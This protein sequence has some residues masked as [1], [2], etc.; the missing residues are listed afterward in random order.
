MM[1]RIL[2]GFLAVSGAFGACVTV[3]QGGSVQAAVDAAPEGGA[4]ICIEPGTYREHLTISK[5]HIQ[6]VG[7]GKAPVDVVITYDL[8]AGTAGGTTKS[9]SVSISGADFYAENLTFENS[10]SRNRHARSRVALAA[11]AV[12]V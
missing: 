6:L 10:F 1:R 9:A 3:A 4:S 8:S 11:L 7:M 2:L 12:G 5:A